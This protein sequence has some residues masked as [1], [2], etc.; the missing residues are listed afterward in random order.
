MTTDL[1]PQ[2]QKLCIMTNAGLLPN[3]CVIG[4]NP[5]MGICFIFFTPLTSHQVTLKLSAAETCLF[6]YL[7]SWKLHNFNLLNC[8]SCPQQNHFCTTPMYLYL[9]K[10]VKKTTPCDIK[11]YTKSS[12]ELVKLKLTKIN[13]SW[14]QLWPLARAYCKFFAKS[15]ESQKSVEHIYL[16][17]I[18][19][20]C[21]PILIWNVLLK[22]VHL[23]NILKCC[24]EP[25]NRKYFTILSIHSD[26]Q[27]HTPLL[28]DPNFNTF[29]RYL[30]K[31]FSIGLNQ[32]I[33]YYFALLLMIKPV[34][35]LIYTATIDNLVAIQSHHKYNHPPDEWIIQCKCLPPYNNFKL[36]NCKI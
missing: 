21:K 17:D 23:V 32:Q 10:C 16:I 19:T 3:K 5:E 12:A 36:C 31:A 29:V 6:W 25:V 34:R 13:D 35:I 9:C 14:R 26:L 22:I 28:S 20:N 11:D 33:A 15:I 18:W 8:R 27:P 24:E 2:C 4:V 1:P 7:I 30:S